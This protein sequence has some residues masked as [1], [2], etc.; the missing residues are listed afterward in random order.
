M[1][2]KLDQPVIQMK[3]EVKQFKEK[4]VHFGKENSH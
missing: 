2:K 1:N 3:G 4:N